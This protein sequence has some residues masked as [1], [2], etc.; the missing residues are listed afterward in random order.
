M[1]NWLEAIVYKS[2]GNKNDDRC[3]ACTFS[4]ENKASS[5]CTFSILLSKTNQ[6][7]FSMFYTPIDYKIT[8]LNVQNLAVKPLACGQWFYL[9]FEHFMTSFNGLKLT[10]ELTAVDL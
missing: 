7:Q 1:P 8:S 10:K 5:A 2:A 9:S 4:T 3:N 6:R